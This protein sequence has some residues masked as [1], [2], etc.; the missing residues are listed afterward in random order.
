MDNGVLILHHRPKNIK[1]DCFCTVQA[2]PADGAAA[3][4]IMQKKKRKKTQ[5]ISVIAAGNYSGSQ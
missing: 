5:S 4:Q 1:I 2:C 3:S